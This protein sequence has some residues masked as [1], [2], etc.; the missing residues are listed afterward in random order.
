MNTQF[1]Q[2]ALEIVNS[3][4]LR[5]LS[6][7]D[8]PRGAWG[9]AEMN[10]DLCL[11]RAVDYAAFAPFNSYELK[12]V[13]SAIIRGTHSREVTPSAKPTAP[14]EAER[15]PFLFFFS[16]GESIPRMRC[17]QRYRPQ[18]NHRIRE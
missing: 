12:I 18:E 4:D 7:P 8:C 6:A 3:G 9:P 16:V 2:F 17:I 1:A 10:P 14:N 11:D 13:K 15:H 5:L